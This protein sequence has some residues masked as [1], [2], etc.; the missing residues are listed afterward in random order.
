MRKKINMENFARVVKEHARS[1][2]IVFFF[3]RAN[4]KAK[5][6]YDKKYISSKEHQ[7]DKYIIRPFY[8]KLFH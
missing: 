3:A 8:Y 6:F 2:S 4:E 7:T 5:N 1:S